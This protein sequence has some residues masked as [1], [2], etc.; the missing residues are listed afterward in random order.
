[1][2]SQCG[3]L[4]LVMINPHHINQSNNIFLRIYNTFPV[5]PPKVDIF[6]STT[7]PCG[8]VGNLAIFCIF[9]YGRNEGK[10]LSVILSEPKITSSYTIL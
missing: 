2:S 7:E 8:P 1:M 5:C 9:C 4:P 3:F 6:Q 10:I